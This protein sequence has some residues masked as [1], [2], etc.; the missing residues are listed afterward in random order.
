MS[1]KKQYALR[2]FTTNVFLNPLVFV[3]DAD[4]IRWF[5]TVVNNKDEKNNISEHPEQFSLFRLA[6]Y[7]DSSGTFHSRS[8][9]KEQVTPLEIITG[10]SVQNEEFKTFSVKQL[11][12]MLKQEMENNNGSV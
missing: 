3:N 9:D 4:A 10:V 11:I 1:I 6:N 12:S 2:D 5:G 7:D 8:D